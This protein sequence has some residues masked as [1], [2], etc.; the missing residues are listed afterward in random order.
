MPL[1]NQDQNIYYRRAILQNRSKILKQKQQQAELSRTQQ[2]KLQLQRPSLLTNGKNNLDHPKNMKI[3]ATE[4]DKMNK[5]YCSIRNYQDPLQESFRRVVASGSTKSDKQQQERPLRSDSSSSSSRSSSKSSSNT[6][7]SIP[8]KD[9][10][11]FVL[12]EKSGLLARW[13]SSSEGALPIVATSTAE[14][15]NSVKYSFHPTIATQIMLRN[16]K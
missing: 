4:L 6:S 11:Y 5:E 10:S 14:Q 15:C 12:T 16:K 1:A 13:F 7:S 3:L 8:T 2:H 9:G